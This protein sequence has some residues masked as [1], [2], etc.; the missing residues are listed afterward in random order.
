MW[1]LLGLPDHNRINYI[2]KMGK[3]SQKKLEELNNEKMIVVTD[4]QGNTAK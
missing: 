1:V 4:N 2:R 3:T